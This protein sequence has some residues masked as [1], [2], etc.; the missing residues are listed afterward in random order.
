LTGEAE[1]VATAYEGT[2]NDTLNTAAL[3]VGRYMVAGHLDADEARGTLAAAARKAGLPDS[4][5]AATINSGFNGAR[6][7]GPKDISPPRDDRDD[8]QQ[9]DE[10]PWTFVD[11]ATFIL[12]IP[13]QIPA[14]WGQ[15]NEVLWAEGESLMIAGPMGLGKTTLAGLLIRAQLGVGDGTVLGLP[16][17][18]CPGKLLYLAMDRPAQIARAAHRQFTEDERGVLAERLMVWKGPPPA[19]VARNPTLLARLAEAANAQTVYL[20]SIKDAAIGLSEDEVGAGYNRARQFL[21]AQGV[22]LAECHHTVKRGASGGPPTSV[23][24]I[25]G[26]AWITNGTGS[27]IL[28]TGEPGDPVVGFRHAR[29]PADELGPWRLL[30]DQTA[31]LLTIEHNVDL[32]DLAASTGMSGLT[33]RYAAAILYEQSEPT[34]SHLEKARRRLDQL[35]TNGRLTRIDGTKGGAPTAWFPL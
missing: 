21:L 22:Q 14:L 13:Q 24:D 15:G 30:H 17:P 29:A 11:G 8:D 19:D 20:D 26:S 3:K 6:K 28:L 31:G 1:K 7:Y 4:E 23:A 12:D 25:Y 33:A 35:T 16:V 34:R 2:R 10:S 9:H 32:V 18:E 5:I 27:I